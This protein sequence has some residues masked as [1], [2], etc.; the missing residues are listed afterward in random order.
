MPAEESDRLGVKPVRE[1]TATVDKA[2]RNWG[3]EEHFGIKHRNAE[4]RVC[5]AGFQ[6]LLPMLPSLLF[7]MMMFI[8]SHCMLEV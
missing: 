8:L 5:P 2:E 7:G 4:F 6:C 1:R 3:S